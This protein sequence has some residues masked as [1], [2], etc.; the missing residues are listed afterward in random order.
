MSDLKNALTRIHDWFQINYPAK[1]LS[2]ASGLSTSQ[3][4]TLLSKLSFK[5][6]K[7]IR[8][9]Y[10]WSNGY[11]I[12]E[13]ADDWIFDY[14]FL[15]NLESAV[16]EAQEWVNKPEVT[17]QRYRYAGQPVLP[18][19]MSDIEFLAVVATDV[20]QTTSPVVHISETLEISL[21]YTN[22]TAMMLTLAESYE[23]GGLFIDRKGYIEKD[24]K[25]YAATYRKY[26]S[27][28]TDLA[29]ERFLKIFPEDS[30]WQT[31]QLLHNDLYMSNSYGIEIPPNSLKNKV[32]NILLHLLQDEK[33]D[34]GFSVVLVLEELRAVDALIQGLKHPDKWVRS[35]AAFTLAKIKAFEAV[36]FV[37]QLLEDPDPVVQEAVK[38]ALEMF[39]T[40]K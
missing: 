24:E 32:V 4:D 29:L 2:L 10:Q 36:E 27:E 17:A 12:D 15:L 14:M 16:K 1:I 23:T 39:K 19:F 18:V 34:S 8:E 13:Y 35:R 6:S 26:N 9:I 37:S 22:L 5:V 25:K 33:Y 7:E 3:I 40:Q 28:I 31:V 30:S 11:P 38:E 20:Q 21:Q